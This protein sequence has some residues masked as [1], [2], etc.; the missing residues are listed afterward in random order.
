MEHW[1]LPDRRQLSEECDLVVALALRVC[2][3]RL[4]L[5]QLQSESCSPHG[6]QLRR[7]LFTA[8]SICSESPRSQPVAVKTYVVSVESQ[9][10]DLESGP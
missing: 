7:Y 6:Q 10:Q 1:D 4:L 8:F 3:A 9:M 2:P 5:R